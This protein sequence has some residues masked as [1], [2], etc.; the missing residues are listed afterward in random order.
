MRFQFNNLQALRGVACLLV[1]T[2]HL[3]SWDNLYG[4]HT[5]LLGAIKWFGFAGVDLFFVLSGFLIAYTNADKFGQPAAIPRYFLRRLGRI[6][7]AYWVAMLLTA[8]GVGLLVEW[9]ITDK[10][11]LNDFARWMT[12]TPDGSPN[13]VIWP[14]WTLGYE[15]LFYLV[16]GLLLLL[17][18]KWAG[19]A[20]AT[21]AVAVIAGSF[22]AAPEDPFFQMVVNPFVLEFLAGCAIAAVA[23][24]RQH[25]PG[26]YWASGI[27]VVYAPVAAII[28]HRLID[29]PY[30]S[31]M[32]LPW[33]RVLAFG[34]PSAL[35]VYACV[36]AERAG[37]ARVPGWLRRVGD[38]SYSIYITHSNA[39]IVAVWLGCFI[40]HSRWPH[41]A[42]LLVSFVACLVVG[43]AFHYAV[44]RPLMNL[45][46]ALDRATGR[47]E[48]TTRPLAS[49]PPGPRPA[50][51][52][53]GASSAHRSPA[54]PENPSASVG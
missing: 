33:P 9:P 54:S 14:A 26:W 18:A 49:S 48:R 8:V 28:L 15:V 51:V 16:F 19:A 45:I 5:P 23:Y 52:P 44:E 39:L 30:A 13:R 27:A 53:C 3:W 43:F 7:P 11:W 37:I 22:V 31:I 29:M 4:A 25:L 34:P 21:W 10:D 1:L 17:R 20:L 50:A 6:Y 2:F 47:R 42:W 12:L 24:R 38:A 41:L 32:A 40:P 35:F 46:K 36:A